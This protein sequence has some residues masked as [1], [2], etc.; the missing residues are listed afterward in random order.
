MR[1]KIRSPRRPQRRRALARRLLAGRDGADR[2]ARFMTLA[3][4]YGDDPRR[5]S[6]REVDVGLWWRE[7]DDAPLHRAAWVQD[8][9][10]VYAVRLGPARDSEPAVELLAQIEDE[11]RL[12]ETLAG[13]RERCGEPRSLGWLRRRAAA[14]DGARTA[15]GADRPA[16]RGARSPRREGPRREAPRPAA[17]RRVGVQMLGAH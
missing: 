16:G 2:R 6:S 7:A 12:H 1:R 11:N 15:A 9:G 8:T 5:A 3:A 13:W 4:F 14:A 10:E 17:F